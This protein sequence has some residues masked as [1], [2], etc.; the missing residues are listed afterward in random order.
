[1]RGALFAFAGAYALLRGEPHPPPQHCT[2]TN[3]AVALYEHKRI[4]VLQRSGAEAGP[5]GH[6]H[7]Y[8]WNL[9]GGTIEAGETSEQ[10]VIRE[11]AEEAN[12][13]V[14]NLVYLRDYVFAPGRCVGV[15]QV[16]HAGAVRIDAD[17]DAF[18]WISEDELGSFVFLKPQEQVL[19]MLFQNMAL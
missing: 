5:G 6:G 2:R 9:P 7:A 8:E 1:M 4:L 15:W 12:V 11:C 16:D 13:T 10:A 17:S 19:H 14:S 18:R 3:V